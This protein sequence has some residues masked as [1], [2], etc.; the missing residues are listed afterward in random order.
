[1]TILATKTAPASVSAVGVRFAEEKIYIALSDSRE[2]GLPLS[3]PWL[4]WLANANP[5]QCAS[6]SLEPR[7]FAVYWEA[8]DDGIEIE[9][10]LNAEP[11]TD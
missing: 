9:P 10:L 5:Q 11:L 4:R 2:I 8:L 6:W 1:M 7:G 3:L